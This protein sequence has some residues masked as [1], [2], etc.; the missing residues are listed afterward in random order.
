LYLVNWSAFTP[1]LVA[2]N[3]ALGDGTHYHAFDLIFQYAD[4]AEILSMFFCNMLKAGTVVPHFEKHNSATSIATS[5]YD[6]SLVEFDTICTQLRQLRW[7]DK[8]F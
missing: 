8:L 2:N 1:T 4:V 5:G 7:I 6:R 3:R